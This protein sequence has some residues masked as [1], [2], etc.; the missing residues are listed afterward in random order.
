VVLVAVYEAE[1][2]GKVAAGFESPAINA[3]LLYA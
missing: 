2:S 3:V 1:G